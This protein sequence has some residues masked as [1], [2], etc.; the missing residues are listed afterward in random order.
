MDI[1]FRNGLLFTS[2]EI[3]Y[4]GKSKVIDNIVLD[5]GAASS[6][7]SPDAVDDIGI[8]AELGDKIVSFYGVGG[9]MHNSFVKKIDNI[10]LESS[11]IKDLE[12]DF[13]I[14]D[15]RGE[16]N[17]LLGLDILMKLGAIINLKELSI[18]I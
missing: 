8:Y 15:S 7:I 11:I 10:K 14:I 2:I 4:K 12:I 3:C 13:G 17:G 18:N 1:E 9:S 6:I 16:I 5:T